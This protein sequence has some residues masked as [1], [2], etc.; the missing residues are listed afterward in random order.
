[1]IKILENVKKMSIYQQNK[2]ILQIHT[3][4]SYFSYCLVLLYRQFS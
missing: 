2:A 1:M 4:I 3:A